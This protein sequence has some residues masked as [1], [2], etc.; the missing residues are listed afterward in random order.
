M[1]H[2]A[3]ICI[4]NQ[5]SH[6]CVPY[7]VSKLAVLAQALIY[8]TPHSVIT[9]VITIGVYEINPCDGGK[10]TCYLSRHINRKLE[11]GHRGARTCEECNIPNYLFHRPDH[12]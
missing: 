12:A 3:S 1:I 6:S 9:C 8:A 10:S 11:I 2:A 7:G 4:M 5:F